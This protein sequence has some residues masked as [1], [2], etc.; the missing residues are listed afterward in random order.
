MDS[1]SSV[2]G[3]VR[4]GQFEI[5]LNA[6][7]MY[8]GGRKVALQ[9]QP[10]RV[11]AVL[12]DHP[13]EVVT[14]QDLQS[15]VWPADTYVGFDEGLNTAI[16]KLRAA[17][18][19][20]AENP[21]FIETVPRRGYRFIAPVTSWELDKAASAPTG[22]RTS[23]NAQRPRLAA[24]RLAIV[25]T[26]LLLVSLAI[27]RTRRIVRGFA[28]GWAHAATAASIHSLA[29]LPLENLSNDA[30]QDYFADGMTDQLISSLG[31]IKALRVISRTS[32]MQYKGMRKPIP[33][34]ARELNVDAVVEGTILKS[35]NQVRITAQLIQAPLD[36][37]LW[38][39][40]YQ[41]DLH[42]VLSLQNS[43]AST[44][45]R[46]IQVTI[47]PQERV[48]LETGR[49]VNPQAYDDYLLGRYFWNKRDGG[50]LQKAAEYFQQ[51][52]RTDPS[53]APAYAGLAQTDIIL[54]YNLGPKAEFLAAARKTAEQAVAL[55]PNLAEAHTARAML[56]ESKY[57]FAQEEQEF[58][59]AVSLDPNYATAHHWYG[60]SYLGQIGRF[61]EADREMQQALVLDPVSRIIATDQG[62]LLYWERKYDEAYQQLTK[63]LALDSGFSEAY[64]CRGKVLLQQGRYTEAIADL[65][66]AYRINPANPAI[67]ANLAYGY[68][69]GGNR[70]KAESQLHLFLS[71]PKKNSWAIGLIY[72]GLGDQTQSLDWFERAV[73]EYSGDMID[74]RVEAQFDPLRREPR[75]KALLLAM[76]LPN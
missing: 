24:W 16:R 23:T 26:L 65:E 72:L 62:V 33:Q 18:G 31:Q 45:A 58:K 8:K 35:G 57:D 69:L 76:K 60:E 41:S 38:S 29:V 12:L 66:A 49:T 40:S 22:A 1:G 4:A 14:R 52:T 54:A 20:S 27:P 15:R 56:L 42:D 7:E 19:D 13:G 61:A 46:Q 17:F 51:A 73:R 6:G 75:F 48:L 55:D 59:L 64:L 36:K 67:P 28:F 70:T 3:R 63:T 11:L 10:F 71:A 25:F 34:I 47:T 5:D 53:Y 37:H 32:V 9:E 30:A 43:V 39:Q 50:G 74:V 44:I 2:L 21:R 68:A